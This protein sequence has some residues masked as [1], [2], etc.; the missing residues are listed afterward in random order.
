MEEG[1]KTQVVKHPGQ[2]L[3]MG[4]TP[5]ATPEQ[6]QRM[7]ELGIRNGIG[8]W[9]VFTDSMIEAAFTQYGTERVG[10]MEA[11]QSY[12]KAGLKPSLE[13]DTFDDPP[14]WKFY[15]A[16]TRKDQKYGRV[17]NPAEKVT[18]QEA[19][20]M[21]TINGAYQLGEDNKLGSIEPGK[22]ADFIVLDR[23]YM[24]IPEDDLPKIKVLLTIVGGKV[25][26][27]AQGGLK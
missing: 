22:L 13:G 3:A 4:H 14:F 19:L 8:P 6:I 12:L 2:I 1:L 15:A 11:F 24:T 18:R 20:W 25:V 23:D 16:I 7:K 5:M 21:G 27:E 26:Y 17:W 9:H 10:Q